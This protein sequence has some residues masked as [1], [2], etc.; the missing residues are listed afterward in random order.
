MAA[1]GAGEDGCM[2][3]IK[4]ANNL[5]NYHVFNDL[6]TLNF[7]FKEIKQLKRTDQHVSAPSWYI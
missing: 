3:M 7:I 4:T 2:N 5:R 1:V 6:N